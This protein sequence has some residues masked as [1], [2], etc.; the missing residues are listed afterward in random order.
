[1][2]NCQKYTL[3]IL[4]QLACIFHLCLCESIAATGRDMCDWQLAKTVDKLMHEPIA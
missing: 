1:M 3:L 2:L 4:A